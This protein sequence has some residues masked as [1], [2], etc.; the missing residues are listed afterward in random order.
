MNRKDTKRA[1][2]IERSPGN[3]VETGSCFRI[4]R[5]FVDASNS[6]R[7]QPPGP[8]AETHPSQSRRALLPAHHGRLRQGGEGVARGCVRQGKQGLLGLPG[9]DLCLGQRRGDSP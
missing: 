6:C 3:P 1:K 9:V 8:Q 5:T 7:A 2:E 4:V